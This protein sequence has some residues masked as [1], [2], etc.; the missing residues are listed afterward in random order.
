MTVVARS[1]ESGVYAEVFLLAAR[2]LGRRFERGPRAVQCRIEVAAIKR[3]QRARG[4]LDRFRLIRQRLSAGVRKSR[5]QPA[6]R[7][8]LADQHRGRRRGGLTDLIERELGE[9]LEPHRRHPYAQP[10]ASIVPVSFQR[11]PLGQREQSVGEPVDARH[12]GVRIVD[13]G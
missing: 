7:V 13:R 3:D 5:R 4:F 11:R 8:E 2:G 12:A 1:S 10:A 6:D 9:A